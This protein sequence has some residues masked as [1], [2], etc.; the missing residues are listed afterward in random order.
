MAWLARR[1]GPLVYHL[2]RWC[3]VRRYPPEPVPLAAARK[4]ARPCAVCAA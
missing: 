3:A 4:I 1:H 2:N